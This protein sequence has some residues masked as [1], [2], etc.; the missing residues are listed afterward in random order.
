MTTIKPAK[1]FAHVFDVA[2]RAKIAQFFGALGNARR[3]RGPISGAV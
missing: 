1:K 3:R 2:Q